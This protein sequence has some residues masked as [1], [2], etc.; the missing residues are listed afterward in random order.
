MVYTGFCLVL[1]LFG[2][3]LFFVFCREARAVGIPGPEAKA[4]EVGAK[5]GRPRLPTIKIDNE[6]VKDFPAPRVRARGCPKQLN[7]RRTGG[8]RRSAL[9]CFAL[10]RF[11]NVALYCFVLFC[12]L[13]LCFALFCFV[14]LC[15]AL[16]KLVLLC[17]VL[18]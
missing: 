2:P 15:V 5:G 16:F 10:F 14:L 4:R 3:G 7:R 18:F 11:L 17:F 12:F 6:R 13:L 9:F 1:V 8:V